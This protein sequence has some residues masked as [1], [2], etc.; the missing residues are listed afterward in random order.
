MFNI[1]YGEKKK[2]ITYTYAEFMIEKLGIDEDGVVELNQIL[3]KK[4]GTSMAGLKVI[5]LDIYVGIKPENLMIT[6]PESYIHLSTIN[7]LYG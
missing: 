2:Q 7:N 5:Y 6:G 4:Y 3:Y 1:S